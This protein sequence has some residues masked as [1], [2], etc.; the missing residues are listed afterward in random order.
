MTYIIAEPCLDVKDTACVEVC[1]VDCIHPMKKEAEAFVAG[2]ELA[3]VFG[4][5]RCKRVNG[6][7][8]ECRKC[9]GL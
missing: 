5:E 6:V 4:G 7:V 9:F 8:G 2:I 3:D 1:P